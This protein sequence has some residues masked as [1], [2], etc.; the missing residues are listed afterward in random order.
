MKSRRGKIFQSDGAVDN[1]ERED[2][3]FVRRREVKVIER[4]RVFVV[5]TE[6]NIFAVAFGVEE[7]IRA[8]VTPK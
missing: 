7:F 6:D 4:E 1:F 8:R 2:F 3:V 5:E